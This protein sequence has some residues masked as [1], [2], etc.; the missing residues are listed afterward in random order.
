MLYCITVSSFKKTYTVE[1]SVY[2]DIVLNCT[3]NTEA[4]CLL[5]HSIG[6]QHDKLEK[7]QW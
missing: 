6:E 5:I 4:K 1:T 7:E 2:F 3:V